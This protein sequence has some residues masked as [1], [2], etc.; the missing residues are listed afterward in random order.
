MTDDRSDEYRE[1]WGGID[2]AELLDE[3]HD[4][5]T[6]YVVFRDEH[7]SAAVALWIAATHALPAFE[8]AP[9][10]VF[11]SPEKRC[12]KSRALDVIAGTCHNPLATVNAT[13]AAIFRSLDK[14]HPPTLLIDEADTIFGSKKVAENNEDFRA[15]LNAGFQRGRPALRCVGP[16]QV[17]TEFPT[18]AMAA[19][20]GIHELPDTIADRAVNILLRR[21]AAGERVWQFRARREGP[22]LADLR[23]R[24]ADWVAENTD[25]LTSAEP[26]MPVEDRAAD[27][28]EP[29]VAVADVAGA[30]WPQT[31]RSA[32]AAL[33]AAAEVA[34]ED[35][36]YGVKLLTDIRDIFAGWHTSFIP[37]AELVTELR[38]IEDSPWREFDYTLG[39]LAYYLREFGIKP[40]RAERNTVRGYRL[41]DFRDAFERYTRPQSSSRLQTGDDQP[42]REDDLKREDDSTGPH[43]STRPQ[44]IPGQTLFE[45]ERTGVDDPPAG[46]RPFRPPTGPRRCDECGWH[47]PTQGHRRG[48]SA[49]EWN[50]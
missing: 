22:I 4:T 24:L 39:K 49:N 30:H 20:A 16:L 42:K 25:K 2:G 10:L 7:S 3:L 8:A 38:R 18:F 32:C 43:N 13:V 31:A 35:H 47:V 41:A 12:G 23:T 9:R 6:R 17:P 19:L 45:D 44:G 15:L 50:D 26:A 37:S 40:S 36:S 14:P 21:R 11:T 27:T 1:T 5:L 48:C 34:D 46:K 29:L 28:W 33:V